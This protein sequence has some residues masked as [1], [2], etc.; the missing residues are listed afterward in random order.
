MLKSR[1]CGQ[2]FKLLS[3]FAQ[4]GLEAVQEM[5]CN[6][7]CCMCIYTLK[8]MSKYELGCVMAVNL[9]DKVFRIKLPPWGY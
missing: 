2:Y 8:D 7:V 6:I 4:S 3:M 9:A 5:R 1:N